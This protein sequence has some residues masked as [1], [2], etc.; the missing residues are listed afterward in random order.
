MATLKLKHLI[1]YII[2]FVLCVFSEIPGGALLTLF[3][4]MQLALLLWK[5]D[6]TFKNQ[7]KFFIL[8]LS[9]VP[10]YF[11][12]GAVNSFISIYAKESHFIFIL[13]Y[14]LLSFA[15]C[16][17]ITLFS[18]FSYAYSK[19]NETLFEL[20]SVCISKIKTHKVVF[21]YTTLIVFLISISSLPLTE[22][23]R[24]VLGI[25]SAHAFLKFSE[26]KKL[27]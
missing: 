17:W 26:I 9:L 11:L 21:L 5:K 22:D 19:S 4:W 23:Y 14:G 25:I 2:A 27:I 18:V 6:F 8:F 20:Y 24:I 10:T 12:W 3:A 1:L 13:M 15:V 7:I 16:F